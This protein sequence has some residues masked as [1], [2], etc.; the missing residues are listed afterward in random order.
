[1]ARLIITWPTYQPTR[2]RGKMPRWWD[3][4]AVYFES[5]SYYNVRP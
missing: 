3:Q 2:G 5:T 1:M 4:W